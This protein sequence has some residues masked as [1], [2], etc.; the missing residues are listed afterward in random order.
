MGRAQPDI[1]PLEL[2]SL[3]A[4][5]A[6]AE[7]A[8]DQQWLLTLLRRHGQSV[9]SLLWRM[10]GSVPDVLDSYQ[11]A[12]CQLTAG[13]REAVRANP[14]GYF[15]RIAM[16]AGISILRKRRRQ[17]DSC[18]ELANQARSQSSITV[19]GGP[20]LDQERMLDR[21]R[22]AV[23]KLPPHLRDVIVLRELAELPY[24]QVA[25]ILGIGTATARLYRHK[26]LL[27][28]ADLMAGEVSS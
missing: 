3:L 25:S 2:R 19:D 20:L 8:E 10:L 23:F 4:G 13:G 15:Y 5:L 28:L 21:L 16:N 11:I 12:V 14:G 9:V 24:G 22:Q 7:V 27:R 6:S 18:T 26:G 1:L 17:R